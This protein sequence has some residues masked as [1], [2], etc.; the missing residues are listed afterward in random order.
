MAVVSLPPSVAQ[1][2]SAASSWGVRALWTGLGCG[3][4]PKPAGGDACATGECQVAPAAWSREED[5]R[6][7]TRPLCAFLCLN[8]LLTGTLPARNMFKITGKNN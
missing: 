5:L 4:Q 2:S 8:R 6:D 3:T 1:P 7:F